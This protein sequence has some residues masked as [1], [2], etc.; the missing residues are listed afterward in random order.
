M[1]LHQFCWK[2]QGLTSALRQKQKR[3]SL[4]PGLSQPGPG[5]APM[6]APGLPPAAITAGSAP[7]IL[8]KARAADARLAAHLLLLP[9]V[10]A[11]MPL[12]ILLSSC[13]P[14]SKL[15]ARGG[16]GILLK[17]D[18]IPLS[19]PPSRPTH[20]FPPPA[21]RFRIYG[22]SSSAAGNHGELLREAPAQTPFSRFLSEGR[23]ERPRG[24]MGF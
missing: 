2:N 11:I 23:R 18:S 16:V 13:Q 9:E 20:G 7:W 22:L 5:P 14:R 19:C 21:T 6:C 15:Q 12:K 4:S 3:C 17:Q 8:L 1:P 24:R 10:P